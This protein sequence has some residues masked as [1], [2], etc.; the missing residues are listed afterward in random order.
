[1]TDTVY[2]A[3]VDLDLVHINLFHDKCLHF[4]EARP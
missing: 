3:C 1:M 2:T 4:V